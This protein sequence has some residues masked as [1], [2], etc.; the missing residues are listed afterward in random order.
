MQA[1]LRCIL[2]FSIV[3]L[4]PLKVWASGSHLI[5]QLPWDHQ[6]QFAGFY[7]ALWQ[8]YYNEAGIEVEIRS[9]FNDE[10]RIINAIDAIASGKADI[11]PLDGLSLLIAQDQGANIVALAPILQRTPWTFH[12][13]KEKSLDTLSD[14]AKASV[15]VSPDSIYIY[16]MLLQYEL[17]APNPRIKAH[18]PPTI[19]NLVNG[20]VEVIS[21][22]AGSTVW[23][24]KQQNIPINTLYAE[25]YGI[26]F[27]ADVI[28]VNRDKLRHNPVLVEKFLQATL[29]GWEYA[30]NNKEKTINK[31]VS[32]Y[33]RKF[34]VTDI[35]GLN[36]HFASHFQQ[37][38]RYP[39][40]PLG[41]NDPERWAHMHDALKK[42]G[43][44][45]GN[46]DMM[47]QLSTPASTNESQYDWLLITL[48]FSSLAAVT[49]LA[50]WPGQRHLGYLAPLISVIFILIIL[51]FAVALYREQEIENQKKETLIKLST[52]R[53]QLEESI[54]STF[55]L[56]KG[57]ITHIRLNPGLTQTEFEQISKQLI[58]DQPKINNITA[59]PD[60]IVRM[61]YPLEDNQQVMNLDYRQLPAQWPSVL[62]AKESDQA[63]LTGPVQLVQGGVGLI[64]RL[65]IYIQD[66]SGQREFWGIIST[67]MHVDAFYRAAGL[68]DASLGLEFAI[69]GKNGMG[70]RG[71]V[72]F[73]NGELFS[74]DRS[75][76]MDMMIPGGRWQIAAKPTGD[77]TAF[78]E[79]V[80]FIYLLGSISII[81]AII[82][83]YIRRSHEY[84]WRKNE[85]YIS[86]LAYHD[87]LTGL[88]NRTQFTEELDRVLAH[89]KRSGKAIAVLMLD[90]DHFKQIND[91]LGH[92]AGDEIL[93]EVSRRLK[94]RIRK[95]DH[96]ARLGG[97]EFVIIQRDLKTTDDAVT[98]AQELIV[99]LSQPYDIKQ[100]RFI[101]GASIGIAIWH[102]REKVDANLLEEAD[103][104]LYKAKNK[105]RGS[106]A[107]HTSEMTREIQRRVDLRCELEKALNTNELSLVYQPQIDV[108]NNKL[109]G[110]E[111]LLRWKHPIHGHISPAEFIPIAETHGM[112]HRLG[113]YVLKE[114]CEALVR[115]RN[116]GFFQKVMAVNISPGQLNNEVFDKEL[117]ELINKVGLPGDALELEVTE[118]VIIQPQANN[119][120]ILK[121]LATKGVK[122]AMDNFGTGYSSLPTLKHWPFHRLKIAQTFVHGMLTNPN[123][124]KI[125]MATIGLAENLGLQVI[126][127]GVEKKEQMAF[128]KQN[129]CYLIQ[130]YLLARPMPENKL[131]D[132]IHEN[133]PN[134][135]TTPSRPT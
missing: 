56:L 61:V 17:L 100:T 91:T 120:L 19:D 115:W 50:G 66:I 131:L 129:G 32:I 47:R 135:L 114:A 112:M 116:E 45:N 77:L 41:N 105:D 3:I 51:Y 109:I 57:L 60:L 31:I 110:T 92:A 124:R 119:G 38:S 20:V 73:G 26:D 34:Q 113:F 35:T 36:H 53:V 59:A 121:V 9:G 25:N 94:K 90:L 95:E 6:F 65:P 43:M 22:Y 134:K 93:I 67:V 69:R 98:F 71:E 21:G 111:A 82:S 68:Y 72:F 86:Y 39:Q 103:I 40:V 104:A 33:P 76:L 46:F 7:Q 102:P 29:R 74:H 12:S 79:P 101:S 58:D 85:S 44:V 108:N 84:R 5:V 75:V 1:I 10:G 133:H 27:Y 37:L 70:D 62:K 30:L 127:E 106:Y 28:S 83:F 52:V 8:G 55:F 88:P 49:L 128:L 63:V 123:D 24:A 14:L 64:G 15:A 130:G 18:V 81:L 125:V 42:I 126:A 48:L 54:I 80:L 4:L 78:S 132:W 2:I 117:I 11:A 118:Q 99:S 89:A 23:L 97:D 16:E 13:L 122:L 87:S 96:I 107:F